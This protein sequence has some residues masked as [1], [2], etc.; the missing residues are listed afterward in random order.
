[1]LIVCSKNLNKS[2]RKNYKIITIE[3]EEKAFFGGELGS[4]FWNSI[5]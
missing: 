3:G 4:M 2:N 5:N 1:M